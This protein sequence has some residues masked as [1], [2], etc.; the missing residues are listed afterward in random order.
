MLQSGPDHGEH[1]DDALKGLEV[2]DVD[3]DVEMDHGDV[4]AQMEARLAKLSKVSPY[5]KSRARLA[6]MGIQ[7]QHADKTPKE[8]SGDL[9]KHDSADRSLVNG[10]V[11]DDG[12]NNIGGGGWKQLDDTCWRPCPIGV[13]G[14]AQR[15]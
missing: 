15:A 11:K 7:K 12:G 10:G 5:Q 1:D 14:A 8:P 13:W 4:L 2:E 6:L 9:S 3:K